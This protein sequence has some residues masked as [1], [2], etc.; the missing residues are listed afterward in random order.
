MRYM[1]N[2]DNSFVYQPNDVVDAYPH[3]SSNN[4][5][6]EVDLQQRYA[7]DD[8]LAASQFQPS[9]SFDNYPYQPSHEADNYN[10]T[11]Q[12]SVG[13]QGENNP[14]QQPALGSYQPQNRLASY[15]D[16]LAFSSRQSHHSD[17][18]NQSF[19]QNDVR[20]NSATLNG[21]LPQQV[22]LRTYL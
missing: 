4:R 12:P 7:G 14:V 17:L 11:Q 15:Q 5:F 6:A 20:Q 10:M 21:K 3:P 1:P 18:S 8:Q 16:D 13:Y 2:N 19:R 9:Y 22:G